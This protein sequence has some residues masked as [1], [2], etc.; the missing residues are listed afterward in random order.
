MAR[1]SISRRGFITSDADERLP[2]R[3]ISD[4]L[5][6]RSQKN[7]ESVPSRAPR[8]ET[9][10]TNQWYH[11]KECELLGILTMKVSLKEAKMCATPKTY[12]PSRT[13]GPS[14]T[15]S[16]FGSRVFLLPDCTRPS[17]TRT[18]RGQHRG[19]TNGDKTKEREAGWRYHGW[20]RVLAAAAGA[21]AGR[22]KGRLGFGIRRGG[23]RRGADGE[24]GR[25][26]PRSEVGRQPWGPFTGNGLGLY[27]VACSGMCGPRSGPNCLGSIFS[28][29][30]FFSGC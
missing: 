15:F 3:Q 25:D 27:F 7:T 20:V 28:G 5:Q 24:I 8:L 14:V 19:R 13:V 4:M 29:C 10:T 2:P 16:S 1:P 23:T 18:G 21:A 6:E 9:G 17:K 11:E 22:R 12:S 26:N 30:V